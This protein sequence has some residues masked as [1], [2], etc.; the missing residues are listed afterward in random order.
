MQKKNSEAV[1][2]K[3][4]L[5]YGIFIIFICCYCFLSC[6]IA[7]TQNEGDFLSHGEIYKETEKEEKENV[8]YIYNNLSAEEYIKRQNIFVPVVMIENSSIGYKILLKTGQS[9]K[10]KMGDRLYL[11]NGEEMEVVELGFEREPGKGRK[12]IFLCRSGRNKLY[13]SYF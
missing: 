6:E 2:V 10:M 8:K 1:F 11:G 9:Y 5:V 4:K 3:K 7:R 13:I 12:E